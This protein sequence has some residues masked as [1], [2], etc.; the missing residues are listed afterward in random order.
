[1]DPKGIQEKIDNYRA[2]R[3]EWVRQRQAAMNRADECLANMNACAGAIEALEGLLPA[4]PLQDV[5]KSA[6]AEV[7]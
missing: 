7:G 1:M 4:V 2:S 5:L 3:E 6:G